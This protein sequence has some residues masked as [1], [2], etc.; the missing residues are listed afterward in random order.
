MNIRKIVAAIVAAINRGSNL[1]NRGDVSGCADL[2]TLT[3]VQLLS[4]EVPAYPR[5]VL[6]SA[7]NDAS[8]PARTFDEQAWMLRKAFDAVLEWAEQSATVPT[9]EAATGSEEV[10]AA[11]SLD[12][13]ADC[14]LWSDQNDNV[15]GGVSSGHFSFDAAAGAGLFSGV[16]RTENNGGF[17]SVRLGGL[18]LDARSFEGVYVDVASEDPS[19]IFSFIL[20]DAACVQMGGVNFK[21]KFTAPLKTAATPWQ[22]VLLPFTSFSPEFRGRPVSVAP[23]D[24]GGIVQLSLM[25][26]K[27]PGPFALR[28][29]KIGF[30]RK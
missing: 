27:P 18:R 22:R 7:V 4:D 2:Y 29:S 15:M 21:S 9:C 8:S 5:S 24:L 12:S 11:V 3:A 23:L 10:Q 30:F 25:T 16:V 19:R 17:A 13:E 1:Y 28:I 26:M 20:K 14:L 6:T